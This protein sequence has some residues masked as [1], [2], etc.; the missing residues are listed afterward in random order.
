MSKQLLSLLF[1]FSVFTAFAQI[2]ITNSDMPSIDD[3]IR[4]SHTI[5]AAGIDFTLT[6]E[7]YTWDFSI[8]EPIYQTVDTFVSV[9]STPWLYKL[10]FL[11]SSNLAKKNPEFNQ[12]P[13]LEVTDAYEFYNN[14]SN[15]F[16][17]VGFGVTF[18]SIPLPTK[19]D[20]PDI[21]YRF[22]L[23]YGNQDSSFAEYNFDIPSLVYIGGWKKRVNMADGWGELTTPYG[24]FDVVRVKSDIY[25]YDS[26]YIDSLGLGI[27]VYREYTE[28][29]WL[30]N[31]FGLPL[32][33]VKVETMVTTITYT[34]SV[35]NPLVPI[36]EKPAAKSVEIYP[37]P[38]SDRFTVS[39]FCENACSLSFGLYSATGVLVEEIL[40]ETGESGKIV[41]EFNLKS[42]NLKPGLYILIVRQGD[43]ISHYKMVLQ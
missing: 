13:G 29:K 18:N 21:I 14:T 26:L 1:S 7:N 31:G 40:E 4:K 36:N 9:Q 35:R 24:T 38:F 32:C 43:T 19:Y 42:L 34:D 20:T 11:T 2:S 33:E 8:F 16:N 30:G 3:T 6:G 28:Y 15:S 25:Q 39:T 10:V 41:R 17:F 5:N 22:P 27:P 12:I 23:N 37:N